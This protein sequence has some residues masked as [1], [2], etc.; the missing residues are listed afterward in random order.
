MTSPA[1]QEIVA[2]LGCPAAGNPAQYLFERAIEAAGLDWRFVTCDVPEDKVAEAIAGVG[3]LGFRGCI[4]SGPLREAALPLVT[5][6]SPTAAFSGAVSLVERETD[7]ISGHMTDGRGIV[8]ALR[9]HVDPAGAGILIVGADACGRAAALE[10]ALADA[11]RL[12]VCDPDE[13]RARSLV[14]SLSG[15]RAVSA[16]VLDWQAEIAL[17]EDVRVIVL[18][19][20]PGQAP[21]FAGLRRD[22]V[23]ADVVL[24]AQRSSAGARAAE[25]GCC[26]VDGLEIHAAQTAIDFHAFTGLEADVDMLRDALEE[27][28]S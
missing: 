1:L 5:V 2:L 12:V 23:V 16:A 7:G 15:M 17:P 9:A 19:P 3:A 4:L 27:F 21:A 14:D 25:S 8:E 26:V 13:S 10:L 18:A 20:T 22:L 28:L 6:A 24:A 11:G